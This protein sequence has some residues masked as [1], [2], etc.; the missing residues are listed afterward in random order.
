VRAKLETTGLDRYASYLVSN[1]GRQCDPILEYLQKMDDP[2]TDVALAKAELWFCIHHEMVISPVDFFV[3][4]TGML[5]FHMD[6]LP[7]LVQSIMEEF[8]QYFEWSDE[9]LNQE[10]KKLNHAI[11]EATLTHT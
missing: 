5:F 2:G 1:Y 11:K 6:R 10:L 9:K 4:R 8:K 7:V 3:R